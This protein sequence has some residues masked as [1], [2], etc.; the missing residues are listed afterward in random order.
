MLYVY[1]FVLWWKYEDL[2]VVCMSPMLGYI[3]YEIISDSLHV[4]DSV[5]IKVEKEYV[6]CDF[7]KTLG[8]SDKQW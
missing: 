1:K 5:W 7:T 4:S 6:L 3:C 8:L 2:L